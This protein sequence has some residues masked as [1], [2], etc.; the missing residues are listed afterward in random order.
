MAPFTFVPIG[1]IGTTTA[2]ANAEEGSINDRI[3]EAS[4]EIG[5]IA[6]PVAV[7]EILT[8]ERIEASPFGPDEGASRPDRETSSLG[9]I[10]LVAIV[11]AALLVLMEVL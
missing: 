11:G 4:L 10:G 7:V 8:G 9:V 1:Q 5:R 3:G 2:I 6:G